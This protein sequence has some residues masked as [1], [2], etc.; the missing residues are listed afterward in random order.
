MSRNQENVLSVFHRRICL[1]GDAK[2]LEPHIDLI[3]D[4]VKVEYRGSK[5]RLKSI[6]EIWGKWRA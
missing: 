4:C 6:Y 2:K 1:E 5:K 3:G